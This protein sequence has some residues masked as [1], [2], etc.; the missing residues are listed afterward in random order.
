MS[1]H[2]DALAR[3]ILTLADSKRVMGLRYSDWL[4]G[5]PSLETGIACSSMAQDEWGHARLLYAMLK[6]LGH[7]PKHVE[8]DRGDHEYT[9]VD[10]LD[11]S[12]EDWVGLVV[13]SAIVD[14]ALRIRLAGFSEGNFELAG[15]RGPKMLAEEELHRDFA[16]A[17]FRSLAA[18]SDESRA[19][20]SREVARVLPRTLGWLLADDEHTA[21]LVSAGVTAGPRE[22]N[23]RFVAQVSPLL[24]IV[25]VDL[26]DPD[27]DDWD[28][29]RG[30]GP[31]YPTG[32]ALERARGDRNRG[33]LVE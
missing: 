3:L 32:D 33:L 31:G 1:G 28:A 15:T 7:D 10:A 2:D 21:T 17:W 23:E 26:P 8:H 24:E 30:R 25:G 13:L 11:E 18:A 29:D 14:E 6:E 12:P 20:L 9:S 16:Q 19:A 22:L 5:A 27:T 4:L